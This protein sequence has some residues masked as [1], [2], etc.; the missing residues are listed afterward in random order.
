MSAGTRKHIGVDQFFVV[1]IH[2][3][4]TRFECDEAILVLIKRGINGA[5][6]GNKLVQLERQLG[7]TLA[8]RLCLL[9]DGADPLQNIFQKLLALIRRLA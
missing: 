4:N 7:V 5:G 8:A 2:F 3:I 1:I 6:L 9:I